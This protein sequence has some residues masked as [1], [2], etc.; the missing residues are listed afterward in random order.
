MSS[1]SFFDTSHLIRATVS[2]AKRMPK[3]FH[4]FFV[5]AFLA[6]G[7]FRFAV[8]SATYKCRK[9][10]HKPN[11]LFSPLSQLRLS[12]NSSNIS[13][14]PKPQAIPE[15]VLKAPYIL[16]TL[17]NVV[18]EVGV[19]EVK[20]SVAHCSVTR[21]LP[22]DLIWFLYAAFLL[23]MVGTDGKTTLER[24]YGFLS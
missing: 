19:R 1:R 24:T 6:H 11:Q 21:S 7:T 4:F 18:I 10:L 17:G 20:N 15:T 9:A 5:A 22:S 12:K 8:K 2:S 16:L 23:A 3:R 13:A 14:I